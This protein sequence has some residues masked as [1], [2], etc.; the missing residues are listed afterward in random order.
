[1]RSRSSGS[2]P[3]AVSASRNNSAARSNGA[4]KI[5]RQSNISL[6]VFLISPTVAYKQRPIFFFGMAQVITTPTQRSKRSLSSGA[7]CVGVK[8][9]WHTD[10]KGNGV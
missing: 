1:M 7:K 6:L 5:Q 4:D 2:T 10:Y 9:N 8:I 3:A